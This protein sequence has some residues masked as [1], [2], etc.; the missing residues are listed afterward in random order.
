M[1]YAQVKGYRSVA[2]VTGPDALAKVREF[3]KQKKAAAKAATE[4]AGG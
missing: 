4:A 1:D 3:K 2:D